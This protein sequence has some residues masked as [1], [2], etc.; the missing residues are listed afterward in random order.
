VCL[1]YSCLQLLARRIELER[2]RS[3]NSKDGTHASVLGVERSYVRNKGHRW[4]LVTVCETFQ[5]IAL[6]YNLATRGSI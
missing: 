2:D 4:R 5:Y 3:G 6:I 1:T